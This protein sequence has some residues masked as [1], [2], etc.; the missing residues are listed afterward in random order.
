M[1]NTLKQSRINITRGKKDAT[2]YIL[3]I[4]IYIY[5]YIYVYMYVYIHIYNYIVRRFGV[6]FYALCHALTSVKGRSSKN[7]HRYYTPKRLVSNLLCKCFILCAFLIR[8]EKLSRWRS[9]GH[10]ADHLNR[11][12]NKKLSNYGKIFLLNLCI[13]C[14]LLSADG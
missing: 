13:I 1:L 10:I 3:Y 5:I 7:T 11:F 6:K 14:T 4:Y 8:R 12:Q 2:I 9:I